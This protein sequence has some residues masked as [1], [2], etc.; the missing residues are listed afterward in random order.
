MQIQRSL[1]RTAFFVAFSAAICLAQFGGLAVA[2]EPTF[3]PL[4]P[5]GQYEGWTF[6]E[7]AD[8]AQPQPGDGAP[9]RIDDDM[10]TGLGRKTWI[11]SGDEFGDF[12]LRCD[13][14]VLPGAEGGIGLRFAPQ[15][16]PAAT[17]LEIQLVD[18][19]KYYPSGARPEQK[20]G[21]V[22][23]EI[24]PARAAAKK[25]G[26][27]NT[28]EVDCAGERVKV[29]INDVVVQDIDLDKQTAV[30]QTGRESLADRP[31]RGRIGF[32][33]TKGTVQFRKITIKD[34]DLVEAKADE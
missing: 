15:G 28:L 5:Q 30:R 14:R 21:A 1:S 2:V 19:K 10:L 20:T 24:P 4:F 31:R 13:W 26:Q 32:Q 9:W 27:W 17:G 22:Y 18:E 33:N 7:W 6:G 3:E 25:A 12:T 16:D 34:L 23:G 29:T 11:F 8:V